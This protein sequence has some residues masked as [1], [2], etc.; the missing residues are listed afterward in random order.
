ME[1]SLWSG[2]KM[3]SSVEISQGR[4]ATGKIPN[5]ECSR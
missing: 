5:H 4:L 3:A 2:H 1:V